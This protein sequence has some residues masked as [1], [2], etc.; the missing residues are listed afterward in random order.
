MSLIRR[1]FE[2]SLRNAMEGYEL[3]YEPSRWRFVERRIRRR[4]VGDFASLIAISSAAVAVIGGAFLYHAQ[5][6]IDAEATPGYAAAR[7]EGFE[8]VSSIVT[9][10]EREEEGLFMT[11]AEILLYPEVTRRL[12]QSVRNM[13]VTP[14]ETTAT[15]A[16]APAETTPVSSAIPVE[17]GSA[18]TGRNSKPSSSENGAVLA[19]SV[20]LRNAC[21]GNEIEFDVANGPDKGSYLWNFGD[22]NF[23]NKPLPTHRYDKAGT[24]DVSLSVTDQNGRITTNVMTGLVTINPA[25]KA[26]FEWDFAENTEGRPVVKIVNTTEHGSKF[27]WTFGDGSTSSSIN[28]VKTV[29]Q[30][31]KLMVVLHTENEWGCTDS[32]VRYIHVNHDYDLQAQETMVA[33]KDVFMPSALKSGRMNFKMKIFSGDQVVYETSNRNK[34]WDGHL[35]GGALAEAGQSYTWIVIISNETTREEKFF[36]GVVRIVN[37]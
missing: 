28:P 37:P 7:M 29:E 21:A 3:P 34:G 20:S 6:H 27:S 18:E 13:V 26:D 1:D 16:S 8:P 19:M 9:I 14:A 5:N 36:N 2:E 15:A 10:G 31:G 23:S 22:G 35:P 4:T 17:P 32:K 30:D 12:D 25:P 24:F 33:R 11:S